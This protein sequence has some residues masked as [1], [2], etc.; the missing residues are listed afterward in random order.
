VPGWALG[1]K[2]RI[3]FF[4]QVIIYS[5]NF[6]VFATIHS[7]RSYTTKLGSRRWIFDAVKTKAL[8][9]RHLPRL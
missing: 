1:M 5:F 6:R 3:V 7:M 4:D 9:I 8:S 2:Q